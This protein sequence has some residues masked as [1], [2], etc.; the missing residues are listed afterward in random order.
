MLPL[1]LLTTSSYFFSLCSSVSSRDM[2]RQL[3]VK[4][5]LVKYLHFAISIEIVYFSH[6]RTAQRL[7]E[8]SK[9]E[10]PF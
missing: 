6:L 10:K 4:Y 9:S 1:L 3:A 7:S 5:F 2:A 8:Q